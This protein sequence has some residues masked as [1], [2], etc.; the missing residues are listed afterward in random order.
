MTAPSLPS[1]APD[2]DAR[3]RAIAAAREAYA[4]DFSYHGVNFVA[5][6]PR[7]EKFP[8]HYVAKGTEVAA[9]IQANAVAARIRLHGREAV[10]DYEGMFPLLPDPLARGRWQDDATFGWQRLAGPAPVLLTRAERLPSCIRIGDDH[11]RRVLRDDAITVSRALTA[12]RLFL[13]D[14]AMFEGVAAGTTDGKQKYLWAP[15]SLYY[16]DRSG[17]VPVAIQ[18]GGHRGGPST[19]YGPADPGWLLARTTVQVADENLQ[20]VLVH[21]GWCHVVT[22]AF[23]LAAHRQLSADHP[24]SRL[25]M[26][27][28]EFTLDVNDV[29]RKSVVNPGGVQ[30]RLLAPPIAD[31]MRLLMDSVRDLDNASLDPTIDFT[32]RGVLD[33]EALPHY[34]PRDDGLPLWDAEKQLVR[35]YVALWYRT[36]ADVAGDA[37][38]QAFVR[39]VGTDGRLPRLV[40]GVTPRT[41]EDV[42]TLVTRILYRATAYHATINDSSY[43]WVGL[44]PNMPTA[45]FGPLPPKGT[46]ADAL[47][48]ML[49]APELAYEAIDATY[50]VAALHVNHLGDYPRDAFGDPRVDPLIASFRERLATIEAETEQRNTARPVPYLYLLPSRMTRSI[51]A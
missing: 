1:Q 34:P 29:A 46:G 4:Y 42:T 18:T 24:L 43:D 39:E 25:L 17:L 48:S 20:G 26:P 27:H 14:H 8:A 47:R 38:L 41:P 12:G 33:R 22:Q 44:A 9:R 45:A 19:L 21:M 5:E 2:P 30:D 28:F 35:D 23:I 51:N 36:D 7:A 50:N 32:R 31:Q 37:E 16:A 13:V 15:V 49:P 40:E 11:L 10:G 3:G 6:L